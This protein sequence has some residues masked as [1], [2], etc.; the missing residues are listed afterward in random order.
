MYID[1]S[2]IVSLLAH[3][4]DA[5][6]TAAKLDQATTPFFVTPLTIYE[7]VLSLARKSADRQRVPLTAQLIDQA[8]DLVAGFLIRIGADQMAI[9]PE[10]GHAA[11][12]AAKIY[13]RGI[14]HPARL[15][16]GDCFVYAA[17]KSLGVPLL[18]KGEDFAQTDIG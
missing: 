15:N 8:S 13:G 10:I 17:V 2:A 4:D 3:E 9:T 6:Q 5:P 18:Y 11:V 7:A 1:A 16:F 14:G 12:E